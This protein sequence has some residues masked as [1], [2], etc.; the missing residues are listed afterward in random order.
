MSVLDTFQQ[1]YNQSAAGRISQMLG[2]PGGFLSDGVRLSAGGLFGRML[3]APIS[4]AKQRTDAYNQMLDDAVTRAQEFEQA[5]ADKAMDFEAEQAKN[6]MQFS[7][8]QAEIAR[9]WQER[10]SNT[11][12]QRAVQDLK[13]AGLNPILAVG[14]QASTPQG[15]VATSSAGSARQAS[16]KV[17]NYYAGVSDLINAWSASVGT[18]RGMFS[19]MMSILNSGLGKLA[20]LL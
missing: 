3:S 2:N 7:A 1:I 16:G 14:A 11:A 10:M 13:A 20:N 9:D 8:D 17:P 19:D 18:A 12:Y 5:S 6:A 15:A 4:A